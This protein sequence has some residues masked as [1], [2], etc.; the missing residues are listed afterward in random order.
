MS[1]PFVKM[2]GKDIGRR[3]EEEKMDERSKELYQTTIQRKKSRGRFSRS[4]GEEA[5]VQL[6]EDERERRQDKYEEGKR[7]AVEEILWLAANGQQAEFQE[8]AEKIVDE[9]ERMAYMEGYIY[10]IA[11]LEETLGH[12][13]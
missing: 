3:K 7:D 1:F 9:V 2:N 4:F 8:R 10:A 11:V 12:M 6:K 13:K 5:L